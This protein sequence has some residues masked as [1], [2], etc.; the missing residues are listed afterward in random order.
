MNEKN[1][2]I[3]LSKI[4]NL[5]YLLEDNKDA[6]VSIIKAMAIQSAIEDK[7][8]L[9]VS[10]YTCGLIY[11][12]EKDYTNALDYFKSSK[13]IFEEEGL[14]EFVAKVNLSEAEA[15][16]AQDNLS[17]ANALVDKALILSIKYK[18]PI[19]QSSAL[20]ESGI[21]ALKENKLDKALTQISEGSLLAQ[22]Q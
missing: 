17:K 9:A 14:H 15:Y 8:N 13:T 22:K 1:K 16:I 19:I 12:K 7:V 18:L 2:G 11:L 4:A 3:I 6:K 20:I 5:Q 10:R 21:V